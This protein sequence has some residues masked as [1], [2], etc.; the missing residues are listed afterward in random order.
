MCL[1]RFLLIFLAFSLFLLTSCVVTLPDE[2]LGFDSKPID[3][4]SSTDTASKQENVNPLSDGEIRVHFIDVGQGDSIF[5]E[6]ANGKCMLIDAGERDYAGEVIS[7][8]D[9]LGYGKIDY[10]V[11][12]HPHSDHIGGMQ[13]VV[14]NFEIGNV[15]M[16]EAVSDTQ[17]FINL[18]ETLDARKLSINVAKPNVSINIDASTKAEF[19]AP[20][21]I[22]EDLN[23][24]SAV[25]KLKYGNKTFLFTGDAEIPE[26][27]TIK[28]DISC[29]VLKVGHH[30]SYTSSGNNFLSL[31]KPEIAVISCGKDNEYGH[32]HKE[33]LDRLA[34]AGVDKIYRT[35]I[36]GTITVSTDGKTLNI[37][38]GLAPQGYKW[39]LNISSKKLHTANCES[40]TEMK[41]VNRAYSKRS[42]V[43]LQK[44]GYTLCGSCKPKE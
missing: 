36:S 20:A 37:T 4:G 12:T 3:D 38:E 7:L 26:E 16:P 18:L 14:E 1:K 8:I 13:R 44:L 32:P 33:A 28:A 17:T 29:D 24:C 2:P 11:A 35:D 30:G 27:E 6:L 41:E 25:L 9:C 5:V 34:R 31:A 19:V 42:L 39:V 22:V 43:E 40:A 15:Y 21:I 23:N 10:I